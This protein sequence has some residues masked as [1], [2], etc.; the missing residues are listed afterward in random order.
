MRAKSTLRWGLW[1]TL[2][3]MVFGY[4]FV[5]SLELL[6]ISE[7]LSPQLADWAGKVQW[8]AMWPLSSLEMTF[9]DDLLDN[10]AL[11]IL[12]LIVQT[13]WY[14]SVGFIAGLLLRRVV[15]GSHQSCP[16]F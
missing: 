15:C 2:A 9:Y 7:L 16:T 5:Y 14:A 4:A 10:T 13:I 6:R 12:L 8:V 1:G 11:N 3:S